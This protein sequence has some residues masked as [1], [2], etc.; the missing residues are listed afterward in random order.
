VV[1]QPATVTQYEVVTIEAN[2]YESGSGELIWS[3]QLETVV[4]GNL[5]KLIA[6]FVQTVTTDLKE[7]GVI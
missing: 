2:L 3:A 7:K 6:G 5:Q 4:E 1:Y